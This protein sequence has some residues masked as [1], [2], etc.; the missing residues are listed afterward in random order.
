[1]K[2]INMLAAVAA[3][4]L[5]SAGFASAQT[6]HVTGSTAFRVAV[7]S[8]E[9]QV[10]GGLTAKASYF[11]NTSLTGSNYS[12]VTNSSGS[13]VFTNFFNGSIAG[14]E[15]L[16]DGVTTLGFPNGSD[17]APTTIAS[18]GTAS[19][20][21]ANGAVE[22][23]TY[24]ASSYAFASTPAKADIAMSDVA[25][26]TAQKIILASTDHTTVTPTTDNKVG[27]IPFV[28]VLNPSTDVTSTVTGL[29][30]DAQKFT[31]TWQSAGS[32][33]LSFY[34]GNSADNATTIYP[35]GRD[36]DSGTRATALAE[37]GYTLLGS[38]A[39]A[40]TLSVAQYFPYGSTSDVSGGDGGSGSTSDIV[41]WGATSAVP[42]FAGAASG[43]AIA[44]FGLVPAES[45][46]GYA[47]AQGD[48]GFYSGGNLATALST[49]N[50]DTATVNGAGPTVAIGYL[51]VS[52]AK[53]A[54]TASGTN[55]VHGVLMNY[56][57][58]KID[59]ST[60]NPMSST[61]ISAIEQGQYTF[62]GTEHLFS[63]DNNAQGT[64]LSTNVT[65][66]IN[67]LTVSSL[68]E[69]SSYGVT[70]SAMAVSRSGDGL[71]VQ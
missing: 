59:P 48:G 40:I 4:A 61:S 46:D 62:W 53:S 20:G 32:A 2:S 12:I 7:V 51:G 21:G 64:G 42:T 24:T 19:N 8:A 10:C 6:I 43:T 56:N 38:G 1:M 71:N 45:I 14:D 60:G 11:Q 16:V 68:D 29:S 44:A 47:M 67:A 22:S 58:A 36:V 5:S 23:S 69:E 41:G 15:A 3:L 30:M 27:I 65:A 50:S 66:M 70:I 55:R 33:F 25:F 13:L 57:G 37:T 54:L 49:V 9:V 31:Y 63:K 35:M 52:D 28:F 39:N 34:T 18:V 26:T 17:L